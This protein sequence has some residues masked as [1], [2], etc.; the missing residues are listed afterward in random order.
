MSFGLLHQGQKIW[1]TSSNQRIEYQTFYPRRGCPL[2]LGSLGAQ[3]ILTPLK[4]IFT[5]FKGVRKAVGLGCKG[6]GASFWKS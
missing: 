6:K 4:V 1:L 3:I 2:N 5:V